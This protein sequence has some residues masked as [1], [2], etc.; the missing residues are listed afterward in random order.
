MIKREDGKLVPKDGAWK[1]DNYHISKDFV[2]AY[3]KYLANY[4]KGTFYLHIFRTVVQEI[5]F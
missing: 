5:D 1:S 4:L 2:P 3:E